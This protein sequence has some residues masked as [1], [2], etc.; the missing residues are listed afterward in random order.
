MLLHGG[1]HGGHWETDYVIRGES[2]II[3]GIGDDIGGGG[4]L[5]PIDGL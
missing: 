4:S 5:A 1:L 2:D 3:G